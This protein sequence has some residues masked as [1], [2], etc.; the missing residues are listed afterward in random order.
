MLLFVTF[1]TAAVG[2]EAP[3]LHGFQS[4]FRFT[5]WAL[6]AFLGL[7]CLRPR[8]WFGRAVG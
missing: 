5:G 2:A 6:L 8:L 7:T 1:E 3:F 4:T